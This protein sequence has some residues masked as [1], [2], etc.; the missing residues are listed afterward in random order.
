[1][2]ANGVSEFINMS[3][4]ISL[5]ERVSVTSYPPLAADNP[6]VRPD[7][8]VCQALQFDEETTTYVCFTQHP[9]IIW[10]GL[11]EAV[12]VDVALNTTVLSVDLMIAIPESVLLKDDALLVPGAN[13]LSIRFSGDFLAKREQSTA[14]F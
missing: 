3:E 14:C 11:G 12:L 8:L 6:S 2:I 13:L 1:M 7:S 9:L 4:D 10:M 5:F